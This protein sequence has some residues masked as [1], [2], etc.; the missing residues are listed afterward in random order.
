MYE[1]RIVFVPAHYV[2]VHFVDFGPVHKTSII[3]AIE[4][5]DLFWEIIHDTE[6]NQYGLL[7]KADLGEIE[8]DRQP[9]VVDSDH[10]C[11]IVKVKRITKDICSWNLNYYRTDNS[12]TLMEVVKRLTAEFNAKY[13]TN[14]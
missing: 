14:I 1:N 7:L 12:E 6:S 10:I 8:T 5:F 3:E 9:V 11:D 4:N 2:T 13:N